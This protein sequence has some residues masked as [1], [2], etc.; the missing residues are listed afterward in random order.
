MADGLDAG[1][2][3]ENAAQTL[4]I[5]REPLDVIVRDTLAAIEN[6]RYHTVTG[7]R[8]RVTAFAIQHLPGLSRRLAQQVV[9]K[10]RLAT[11]HK[12]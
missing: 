2:T 5:P 8:A 9:R 6:R 12:H 10:A 4:M 7:R 11:G 1:R 3:P